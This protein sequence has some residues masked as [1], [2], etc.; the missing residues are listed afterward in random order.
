[1]I[2]SIG[3]V[4]NAQVT[5]H[6][7]VNELGRLRA[8]SSCA[9]ADAVYFSSTALRSGEPAERNVEPSILKAVFLT[10][11]ACAA[12]IL[13]AMESAQAEGWQ[14][15]G[16]GTS[17]WH[18]SPSQGQCNVSIARNRARRAG[19]DRVDLVY[20]DENVLT[21]RGLMSSGDRG[22][23]SFANVRGCPEVG[24]ADPRQA[25]PTR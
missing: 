17:T 13:P 24:F 10:I 8:S 21:F 5:V 1:L 15:N 16:R 3:H 11:L 19:F 25:Q 22:E 7:P 12:V 20:S 18:V 2:C 6:Y 4:S 9:K 14:S 23:I